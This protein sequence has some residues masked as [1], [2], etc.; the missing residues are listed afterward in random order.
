MCGHVYFDREFSHKFRTIL[1]QEYSNQE[2]REH[3]WKNLYMRYPNELSLY[4]KKYDAGKL[5]EFDSLNELLL[6]DPAYINNIDSD[7]FKN[8]C[9]T[10]HCEPKDV[11]DIFPIKAG[12]TNT[13]F[14]FSVNSCKYVYRHPGRGTERYINRSNEAHSMQVTA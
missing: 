9:N 10:L 14:R 11:D 1:E 12:L 7:I 13:S 2:T 5:L 3:L 6:F 8:I 4:I